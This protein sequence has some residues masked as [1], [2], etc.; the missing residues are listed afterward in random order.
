[1]RVTIILTLVLLVIPAAVSAEE[2]QNGIA[3]VDFYDLQ[4][5]LLERVFS[6]KGNE[7]LREEYQKIQEKEQ[8]SRQKMM[9]SIQ[10][11]TFNPMEYADEMMGETRTTK[12]K[13]EELARGEL[14]RTIEELFAGKFRVILNDTYG[15]DILYTSITI[16]DLTPNVRQ[17]LLRE[18][19]GSE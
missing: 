14:I 17:Y 3:M 4:D 8:K 12:K 11:S 19:T 1:M 16:P 7:G 10:S 5:L 9:E 13:I 2:G 6:R 15:N 18:K